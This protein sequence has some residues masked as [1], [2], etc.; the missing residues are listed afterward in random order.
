MSSLKSPTA[1]VSFL[2]I[3]FQVAE[4]CM[5]IPPGMDRHVQVPEHCCWSGVDCCE[6][7]ACDSNTDSCA[8]NVSSITLIHNNL[9]GEF[10]LEP[11]RA[12]QCSSRLKQIE[13]RGNRLNGQIPPDIT[14]LRGV[15]HLGLST[16]NFSGTLPK[17][18]ALETLQM[19]DISWN[20]ISGDFDM[21][22][23][24]LGNPKLSFLFIA[25]NKL[26]GNFAN[27]PGPRRG[28]CNNLTTFDAQ[29]NNFDES[30][31]PYAMGSDKMLNLVL[32]DNFINTSLDYSMIPGLEDV[33]I[34][35]RFP[36]LT[37][38]IARNAR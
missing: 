18:G 15:E 3:S 33:K 20:F 34:S 10:P 37:T 36:L 2:N 25:H 19:L 22:D 29:D 7:D 30:V 8:C 13:V 16:N 21:T 32:S 4:G 1:S 28:G 9:V 12:L 11:L 26:S 35:T 31:F 24:C 6:G 5:R 14:S 17:L 27:A 23:L 38:L